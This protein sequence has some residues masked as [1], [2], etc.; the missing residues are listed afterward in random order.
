MTARRPR[1]TDSVPAR[2]LTRCET[3]HYLGLSEGRFSELRPALER[4]GFPAIDPLLARYDRVA[5]DAW[6]DI[7]SGIEKRSTIDAD[8][9]LETWDPSKCATS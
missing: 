5:V 3:A 9:E 8:R 7:R 1:F 6:L 4:D 2:G